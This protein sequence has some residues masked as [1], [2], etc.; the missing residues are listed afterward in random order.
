MSTT[1]KLKEMLFAELAKTDDVKKK[2]AVER[3]VKT[4]EQVATKEIWALEDAVAS[5]EERYKSVVKSVGST[6][7]SILLAKKDLD[8]AKAALEAATALKAERF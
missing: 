4:A 5:A 7:S 6:L 3:Q 8:A 1:I 2:E